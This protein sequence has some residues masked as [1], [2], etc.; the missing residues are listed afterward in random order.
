MI[1]DELSSGFGQRLPLR[2]F[3]HDDLATTVAG[4]CF[5]EQVEPDMHHLCWPTLLAGKQ[6]CTNV[7]QGSDGHVVTK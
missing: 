3:S 7:H 1:A 4:Y 5:G 6:S 2:Q